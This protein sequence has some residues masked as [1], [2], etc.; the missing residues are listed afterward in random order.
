MGVSAF[1]TGLRFEARMMRRERAVWFA[2]LALM[3]LA[4]FALGAGAARVTAQQAAIASARADETQRLA[5]LQKTLAQLQAGD[6]Q[7]KPAP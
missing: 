1:L 6:A 3:A 5:N 7:G 2:L 4:L